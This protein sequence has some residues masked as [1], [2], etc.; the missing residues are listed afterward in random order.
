M[1]KII[2]SRNLWAIIA[3]LVLVLV[4]PY[5][6]CWFWY[7]PG[8]AR[9]FMYD[10]R[11]YSVLGLFLVGLVGRV[12]IF[13]K[14]KLGW[15]KN[16]KT[17]DFVDIVFLNIPIL[18]GVLTIFL[19]L[20]PALI[21]SRILYNISIEKHADKKEKTK[22]VLTIF[23]TLLILFLD[24]NK[25]LSA[26]AGFFLF[27]ACLKVF[28]YW[29]IA[30][31]SSIREDELFVDRIIAGLYWI[32]HQS[33]LWVLCAPYK[34][35][36]EFPKENIQAIYSNHGG[37]IEYFL[38][39]IFRFALPIKPLA[40][41]NLL[42]YPLF[43]KFIEVVCVMT[44]RNEGNTKSFFQWF[45]HFLLSQLIKVPGI[46]RT[47]LI[48]WL[49]EKTKVEKSIKKQADNVSSITEAIKKGF[50]IFVFPDGRDR[51]S[52]FLAGSLKKHKFAV[53][54]N[55]DAI[56][57]ALFVGSMRYKPASSGEP[58][59]QKL[60]WRFQRWIRPCTQHIY[61]FPIMH[62]LPDESPKVFTER[63]DAF[64]LQKQTELGFTV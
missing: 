63:I 24:V 28:L 17:E 2:G 30:F 33:V 44:E 21:V 12:K 60:R 7:D 36:G 64:L 55:A 34:I 6:L 61:L 42:K 51:K 46:G 62:K 31:I 23:A 10:P 4:V 57:P 52:I 5:S 53:A 26:F 15:M 11:I 22:I 25:T 16:Q 50:T 45:S 19:Y 13:C 29:S 1:K 49:W 54:K 56:L 48:V 35:H 59:A 8:N 20:V 41:S 38:A 39:I 3:L 27:I 37:F 18:I 58:L 47:R 40:G 32:L 14:E 9:G 43:G